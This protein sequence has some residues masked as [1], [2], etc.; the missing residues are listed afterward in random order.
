MKFKVTTMILTLV[1]SGFRSPALRE[2]A[3]GR[4]CTTRG[5]PARCNLA[6]SM[7]IG[8]W[9]GGALAAQVTG[10]Q[11]LELKNWPAPLYWQPSHV[12]SEA[13]ATTMRTELRNP[14]PE[15]A[16]PAGSLAF[17]AMTPCRVVDTRA[18]QMF[19]APFGAPSLAAG[20]ARSFPIQSSTLC[21]IPSN[22]M[23]Y[24]FNV[25]LVP[26]GPVGY[27]IIWPTGQSQPNIVTVDDITGDIRNN[28]AIVPAGTP[29][30]SVSA[31]VSAN[32]DLVIDINGY[33]APSTGITLTL[34]MASAPSLSFSGDAGTGIFSSGTGTL[35]FATGGTNRLTIRSDGDLDLPGSLRKNG[36]CFYTIWG[37]TVL[38]SAYSL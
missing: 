12:E 16:I 17:V 31:V 29:N 8:F 2:P 5:R 6:F 34:G 36:F 9:L 25:T 26:P 27:L 32:T 22:A 23:A 7:V 10:N 14:S 38:R 18:S 35:N 20:P 21:T 30:G 37:L 4:G 13:V 11:D 1:P 24:S 3:L 28:G 15:A 33:Y 19:P